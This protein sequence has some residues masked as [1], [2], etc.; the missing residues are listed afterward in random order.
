VPDLA[1]IYDGRNVLR[2]MP[3]HP[4]VTYLGVGVSPVRAEDGAARGVSLAGR[5]APR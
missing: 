4:G 2:G 3:A 1:V 5:A